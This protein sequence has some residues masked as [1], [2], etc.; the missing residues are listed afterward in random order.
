VLGEKSSIIGKI[1]SLPN[2]ILNIITI[3]DRSE[4]PPKLPIGP[5]TSKPGPILLSVAATAVKFVVKS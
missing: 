2:S 1:S 5:T 4:K 3:F